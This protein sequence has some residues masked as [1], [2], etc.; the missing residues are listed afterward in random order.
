MIF[1]LYIEAQLTD[2]LF[3]SNTLNVVFRALNRTTQ[4]LRKTKKNKKNEEKHRKKRKTKKNEKKH[5]KKEKQRKTKTS[6]EKQRKTKKNKEKQRKRGLKGR[7]EKLIF[8]QNAKQTQKQRK[9]KGLKGVPPETAP[10]IDF[11]FELNLFKDS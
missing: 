2:A 11:F 4:G 6:K 9:K 3:K 10:N 1:I 5:E 7:A 8:S